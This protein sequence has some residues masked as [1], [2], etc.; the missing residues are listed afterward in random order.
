MSKKRYCFR[1]GHNWRA[2]RH[3]ICCPKCKSEYW[4]EQEY[5]L[6]NLKRELA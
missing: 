4:N 6:G 2:H 3:P 1:C 5:F